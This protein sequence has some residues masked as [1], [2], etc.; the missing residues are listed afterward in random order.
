MGGRGDRNLVWV[1][2]NDGWSTGVPSL[3]TRGTMDYERILVP[4]ELRAELGLTSWSPHVY[5]LHHFPK[6]P[7]TILVSV[8]PIYWSV[9]RSRDHRVVRD[10]VLF[11]VPSRDDVPLP[12][13]GRTRPVRRVT[14]CR[15]GPRS[16]CRQAQKSRPPPPRP[17]KRTGVRVVCDGVALTKSHLVCPDFETSPTG[18]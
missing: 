15:S 6:D 11:M 2:R 18:V 13:D 12:L 8:C 1:D 17:T 5:T 4:T 16:S 3:D 10:K 14:F 7:V 9:T